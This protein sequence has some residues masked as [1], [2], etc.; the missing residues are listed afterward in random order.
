MKP[1]RSAIIR[2]HL[3]EE[4]CW[5]DCPICYVDAHRVSDSFD[6]TVAELQAAHRVAAGPASILASI[7]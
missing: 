6:C 5:H 2:G 3:V 4:F 7:S 1:E